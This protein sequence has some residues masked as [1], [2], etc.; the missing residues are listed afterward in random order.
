MVLL[1]WYSKLQCWV[2]V[3]IEESKY[4]GINECSRCYQW[5]ENLFYEFGFNYKCELQ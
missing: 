1:P 5:Y 4:Y 3:S 2:A